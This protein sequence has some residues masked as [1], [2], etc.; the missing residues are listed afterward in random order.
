VSPVKYELGFYI[1]EDDILHSDHRENLQITNIYNIFNY[2]L[3]CHSN[4]I[5]TLQEDTITVY[6]NVKH[7]FLIYELFL[8]KAQKDFRCYL[9]QGSY[10]KFQI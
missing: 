1:L 4:D 8:N 10:L 9:I 7:I 3:H 6:S 2:N 5:L